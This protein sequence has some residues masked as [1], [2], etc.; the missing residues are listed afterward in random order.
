MGWIGCD[1]DGVLAEYHNPSDGSI[2]RPIEKMVE[3][4]RAKLVAGIE[5]RIVTARVSSNASDRHAQRMA[6]RA[7]C[8][9]QFKRPLRVTA[10]KDRDMLELWDDRARQ[11]V[12]NLGEFLFVRGL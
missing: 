2:G 5:V 10:E 11:V 8:F 6:I 7:W 1:L 4:V 3:K 12:T 9:E